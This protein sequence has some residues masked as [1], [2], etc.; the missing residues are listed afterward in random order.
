[1]QHEPTEEDVNDEE[2]PP[3]EEPP[4]EEAEEPGPQPIKKRRVIGKQKY[5]QVAAHIK[6]LKGAIKEQWVKHGQAGSS[7]SVI[8]KSYGDGRKEDCGY[9]VINEH[10]MPKVNLSTEEP[11]LGK[12]K[13]LNIHPSHHKMMIRNIVFCKW[14][15]YNASRKGPKA[16]RS[17][18]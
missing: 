14:C 8:K 11:N 3:P 18:P 6:D 5:Q 12:D 15:G 16:Y 17:L 10:R 9:E 4:Q 7:Q 1:M 13:F 2:L